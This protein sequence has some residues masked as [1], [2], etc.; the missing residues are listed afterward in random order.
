MV[1]DA[2]GFV[3]QLVALHRLLEL[4]DDDVRLMLAIDT[5]RTVLHTQL[6]DT[7]GE[8]PDYDAA[9]ARLRGAGAVPLGKLVT[10]PF[11]FLDPSATRNPW[12]PEH[13]NPPGGLDEYY[14]RNVTGG[15]G[16]FVMVAESFAWR[17]IRRQA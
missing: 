5:D 2:L 13:T 1:L 14:R 10:T 3:A 16:S 17:V 7:I 4:V 15:P 8:E 12:N 11:A 9:V 6:T